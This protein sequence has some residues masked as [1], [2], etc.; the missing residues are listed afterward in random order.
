MSDLRI[1][2]LTLA[3]VTFF[4]G[5]ATGVI[6]VQA[7]EPVDEAPFADFER[8]FATEFGIEGKRLDHLRTILGNYQSEVNRVEAGH[9]AATYRD[10]EPE[11]NRLGILYGQRIRDK[12]LYKPAQR[13]RYDELVAG[14]SFQ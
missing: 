10:M 6:V 12:V 11:L 13:A 4:A 14:V 2:I 3:T 1:W 7:S 5:V 8:R 9:L